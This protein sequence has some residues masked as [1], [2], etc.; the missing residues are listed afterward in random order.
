[1]VTFNDLMTLLLTFFVMI[2][3]MS[4]LDARRFK[5]LQST[6]LSSLGIVGSE[7]QQEVIFIEKIFKP[8]MGRQ[9]LK[10]FSDLMSALQQAK[11]HESTKKDMTGTPLPDESSKDFVSL[12][13]EGVRRELEARTISQL[14]GIVNEYTHMPG[15]TIMQ[16]RRGIVLQLS[17]NILFEKGEALLKPKAYPLM[18]RIAD[19]LKDTR[20]NVYVEGHTDNTPVSTGQYTSNWELSISRAIS[21]TDHLTTKC[22]VPSERI[23]VSGYADWRPAAPNDTE[24]NKSKNRRVE[25]VLSD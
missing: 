5:E 17:D 14:R 22:S 4:S 24:E 3:S 20:F 21:I 6:M 8:G 16:T 1:M 19:V 9:Q 18:D 13:N 23:G 2:L 25:I 15:I 7:R 10:L 11:K 12:Q